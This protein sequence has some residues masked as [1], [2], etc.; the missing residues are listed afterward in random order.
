MLNR[1]IG[2]RGLEEQVKA[3]R[4]DEWIYLEKVE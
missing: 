3:S 2:E 4:V 1:R